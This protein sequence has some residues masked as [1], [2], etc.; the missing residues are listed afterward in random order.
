MNQILDTILMDSDYLLY[1]LKYQINKTRLYNHQLGDEFN[2]HIKI[3][4]TSFQLSFN[5]ALA[6]INQT[7]FSKIANINQEENLKLILHIMD[8]LLADNHYDRILER[9]SKLFDLSNNIEAKQLLD[10]GIELPLEYQT[11]KISHLLTTIA[12]EYQHLSNLR[13][14][15]YQELLEQVSITNHDNNPKSLFDG[16]QLTQ[17]LI[18]RKEQL[19]FSPELMKLFLV[20]SQLATHGL[21]HQSEQCTY[22]NLAGKLML[23]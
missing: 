2:E 13:Q 7:E 20:I 22:Q 18:I 4:Q 6:E 5:K 8:Y 9:F 21:D 19:R 1:Y 11:T 3:L 10:D 17:Q 16:E 23:H 12:N 14:S 15:K